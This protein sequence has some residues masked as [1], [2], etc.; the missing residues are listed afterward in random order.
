MELRNK[1]DVVQNNA[2]VAVHWVPAR[3]LNL[4]RQ[5]DGSDVCGR[6]RLLELGRRCPD[7]D[8]GGEALVQ[9]PE[10]ARRI[11]HTI[12]LQVPGIHS[13][14]TAQSQHSQETRIGHSIGLQTRAPVSSRDRHGHAVEHGTR[15][16]WGV[17]PK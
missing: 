3:D 2:D 12:E 16:L 6:R 17:G 8:L 5:S 15:H 10:W 9:R 1:R 14:V 4:P 11:G 13:T 7:R